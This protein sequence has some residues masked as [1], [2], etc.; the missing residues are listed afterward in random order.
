[1][2]DSCSTAKSTF[3]NS[4]PWPMRSC[5][6]GRSALLPQAPS[7]PRPLWPSHLGLF[8][9]WTW[10]IQGLCSGSWPPPTLF[11]LI[12]TEL[13]PSLSVSAQVYAR[14]SPFPSSSAP[15]LLYF[16]AL[17]SPRNSVC[18]GE[19]P[20]SAPMR[21]PAPAGERGLASVERPTAPQCLRRGVAGTR[22]TSGERTVHLNPLRGAPARTPQ[23]LPGVSLWRRKAWNP[24]AEGEAV[25]PATWN[26]GGQGAACS[27]RP[28]QRSL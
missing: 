1:M 23:A 8:T 20:V 28:G 5:M 11:S 4:G 17:Y 3:L 16:S 14:M 21:T 7:P 13:P 18:V 6:I 22:G 25:T 9:P 12:S 2:E 26:T 27:H 24:E 15:S 19:S 10:P